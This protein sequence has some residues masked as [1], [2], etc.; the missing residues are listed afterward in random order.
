[1]KIFHDTAFYAS[2]IADAEWDRPCTFTPS[3]FMGK[4][5]YSKSEEL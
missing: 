3:P 1:V 2:T 5:N 4:L